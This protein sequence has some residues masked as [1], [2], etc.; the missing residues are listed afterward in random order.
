VGRGSEGGM[1][2]TVRWASL[3]ASHDIPALVV[4]YF[5]EPGLPCALGDIPLQYFAHAIGWLRRQRRVDPARVWLLSAS[6]GSE[7]ELLVAEHWPGLV[8]GIVLGDRATDRHL[9]DTTV[10]ARAAR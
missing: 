5:N 1:S 4:A 9:N 10:I 3:L 7:A 6:R 8:H 2:Y